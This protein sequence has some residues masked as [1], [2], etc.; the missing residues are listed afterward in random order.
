MRHKAQRSFCRPG[1]FKDWSGQST[2][3]VVSVTRDLSHCVSRQRRVKAGLPGLL[4]CGCT[5]PKKLQGKA[6]RSLAPARGWMS[7]PAVPDL[8]SG[9][10][11]ERAGSGLQH[12]H[13]P[14]CPWGHIR[15]GQN[16]PQCLLSRCPAKRI[17]RFPSPLASLQS[18]DFLGFSSPPTSAFQL[19]FSLDVLCFIFCVNV[20]LLFFSWYVQ[21][22]SIPTGV[23]NS[24]VCES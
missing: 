22:L 9:I 11:R 3:A 7:H 16:R 1:R 14:V 20:T 2:S 23:C 10:T 6:N 17:L 21:T 8:R 13:R 24:I 15:S 5:T 12:R 19:F 4:E 18:S